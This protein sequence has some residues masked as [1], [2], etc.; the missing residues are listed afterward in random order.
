MNIQKESKIITKITFLAIIFNVVL[1][2]VKLIFGIIGKSNAVINS[3][4]DSGLDVLVTV[5]V[6]IIGRFSRKKA[7]KSHPYGHEKFESITTIGFGIVLVIVGIQLVINGATTIFNYFKEGIE[8][9]KPEILA[10]IAVI[11]TIVVK[12]GL[13]IVTERSYKKAKSP[14]L[15]ALAVDH[16]SDVLVSLA[17]LIGVVLALNGFVI[18]E[19]IAGI[20]IA[21]FIGYNGTQLIIE[22]IG[23][24]VDEAADIEDINQIRELTKSVN[25]VIKIDKIRTRKF[26]LK[27]FVDI[28]ISVDGKLTVDEGHDIAEEVHDIIEDKMDIVKHC[29]VHVNPYHDVNLDQ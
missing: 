29:M 24:V 27:L 20:I 9:V 7:D 3:A 6:L 17:L 22:S 28:E 16:I 23:Q 18:F 10:I 15:K 25:G 5:A 11:A 2:I 4:I 21:I 1:L 13:F 8:I 26:G 19:P 12:L 14:A